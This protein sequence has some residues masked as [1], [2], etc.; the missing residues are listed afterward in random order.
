MH[1]TLAQLTLHQPAPNVHADVRPSSPHSCLFQT[2]KGLGKKGDVLTSQTAEMPFSH[3]L[4]SF[5]DTQGLK[6]LELK[7]QN[8]TSLS[9][10]R[11]AA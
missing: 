5:G 9:W 10:S 11:K 1:F 7:K 4:L 3:T 8:K 2:L 6:R